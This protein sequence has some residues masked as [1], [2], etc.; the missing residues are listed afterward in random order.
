MF[1][2][3]ERR[4]G[5]PDTTLDLGHLL[6]LESKHLTKMFGAFSLVKMSTLAAKNLRCSWM[7]LESHLFSAMFEVTHHF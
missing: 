7:Y 4:P 5:S 1:A 3:A 2:F 6:L